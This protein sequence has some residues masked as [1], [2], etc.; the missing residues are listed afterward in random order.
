MSPRHAFVLLLLTSAVVILQRDV[1]FHPELENSLKATLNEFMYTDANG[2]QISYRDIQE[3]K[4]LWKWIECAIASVYDVDQPITDSWSLRSLNGTRIKVP[5]TMRPIRAI[6]AISAVYIG[7][8][9]MNVQPNLG[10]L[11]GINSKVWDDHESATVTHTDYNMHFLEEDTD[12]EKLAIDMDEPTASQ[13]FILNGIPHRKTKSLI[14]QLKK[15]TWINDYDTESV[16]FKLN[17]YN[18]N[19]KRLAQVLVVWSRDDTGSFEHYV[20]TSAAPD[21]GF[22]IF[23]WDSI[24]YLKMMQWACEVLF[25][26]FIFQA[27]SAKLFQILKHGFN[28]LDLE[29]FCVLSMIYHVIVWLMM[30]HYAG[31]YRERLSASYKN[32]ILSPSEQ[33]SARA[34]MKSLYQDCDVTIKVC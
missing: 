15:N 20:V 7:R 30:N 27:A 18:P 24:T 23:S 32:M 14:T 13:V 28:I 33:F 5:M 25:L 21:Q 8:A 11:G 34:V 29:M 12:T 9:R 31:T 26:L 1:L 2:Q 17:V 3:T 19:L 22:Y 16:F 10:L 6:N 4:T